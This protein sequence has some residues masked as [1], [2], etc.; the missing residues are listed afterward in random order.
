[1][2]QILTLVFWF[3]EKLNITV[4]LKMPTSLSYDALGDWPP[5]KPLRRHGHWKSLIKNGFSRQTVVAQ[6]FNP[7][8][9]K[10]EACRSL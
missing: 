1:V 10:A 2:A 3:K 7:S 9:W 5:T 8:T 6:T 4:A